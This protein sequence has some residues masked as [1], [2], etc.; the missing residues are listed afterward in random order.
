MK[1]NNWE[2]STKKTDEA[3]VL[4]AELI[5]FKKYGSLDQ[6]T[7]EMLIIGNLV[8]TGQAPS[9][10]RAE[11]RGAEAI[12]ESNI[13]PEWFKEEE[14]RN[15][16]VEVLEYYRE[17]REK[18]TRETYREMYALREDPDKTRT[19]AELVMNCFSAT[20]TR[21]GYDVKLLLR[22]LRETYM[23]EQAKSLYDKMVKDFGRKGITDALE[24]F[25]SSVI[26][27]LDDPQGAALVAG[28]IID[29]FEDNMRDLLDMK[30]HPEKYI[31]QQCGIDFIDEVTLGFVPGQMTTLVGANGGYKT[32]TKMNIAL[33][34]WRRGLNVLYITLETNRKIIQ[35]RLMAMG[36]KRVS[37]KRLRSGLVSSPGD[38]EEMAALEAKLPTA[39]PE[40]VPVIQK[41][42]Q[43]LKDISSFVKGEW[44]PEFTDEYL[45]RDFSAKMS[46]QKGR[47]IVMAGGD[48]QS[49][50]I[51]FSQIESWIKERRNLF[52]PD[53]VI[54]DY[55]GLV[56]AEIPTENRATDLGDICKYMRKVGANMGF[57][58]VTSAQYNRKAF[59]R[60]RKYGFNSPEKADLSTDDIADSSAI[61]NDSDFV[62][63]L[64]FNKETGKL[65]FLNVKNRHGEKLENAELTVDKETGIIGSKDIDVDDTS[66]ISQS[67]KMKDMN[68]AIQMGNSGLL[69]GHI[70]TED[71]LLGITSASLIAQDD[72]D[73]Y[74]T[75]SI[76][77]DSSIDAV[78]GDL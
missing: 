30:H 65:M 8:T 11:N 62:I 17:N 72:D 22:R 43:R 12:L 78:V 23:R 71:S 67:V 68:K 55:L 48:V 69:N 34:C 75:D 7:T 25:R 50:K 70:E 47:L 45:L 35:K 2:S 74:N 76:G 49:N 20:L 39:T 1:E 51:K 42:L 14:L 6:R 40:E 36:T 63:M 3:P 10:M 37:A 18:C 21:K 28:D 66:S 77:S 13:K 54:V 15:L 29:E 4:S 41:K 31:G 56:Q 58:V 57:H 53:I 33:G 9:D 38:K 61:G 59:E 60:I 24:E 46:G 16:F 26:R 73:E 52:Q 64:W 27:D 32:S 19:R 44:K 5:K